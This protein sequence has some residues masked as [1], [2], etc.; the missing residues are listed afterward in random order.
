LIN[1]FRHHTR[2][3]ERRWKKKQ[4]RMSL[5]E[6]LSRQK[7]WA[8][9]PEPATFAEESPLDMQNKAESKT[10]LHE[11]RKKP[12]AEAGSA[13]EKPKDIEPELSER[14]K[15][16]ESLAQQSSPESS[17][18]A[19]EKMDRPISPVT[20]EVIQPE[21]KIAP[22]S[23]HISTY[24]GRDAVMYGSKKEKPYAIRQIVEDEDTTT[25][26]KSSGHRF[27]Y[28]TIGAILVFLILIGVGYWQAQTGYDKKE[29]QGAP[30][31]DTC[32][33]RGGETES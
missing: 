7:R 6:T 25:S 14:V 5:K 28:F 2:N 19:L 32:G 31:I 18:E 33:I 17:E 26:T 20:D 22:F 29:K 23:E 3:P 30:T 21:E 8:A 27:A 12:Y 10:H 11:E 9:L 13:L 16:I 24:P 4:E 15:K 1:R